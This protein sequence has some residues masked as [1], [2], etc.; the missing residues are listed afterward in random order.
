MRSKSL[1]CAEQVS[2][3]APTWGATHEDIKSTE[4][5]LFQS[6]LPHGERPMAIEVSSIVSCFN[7]RSHMGSDATTDTVKL[8]QKV[9][10]HA[11]T[12]GA[13]LLAEFRRKGWKFQSTLPHGERRYNFDYLNGNSMFQ[14]T[15]P[16]GERLFLSIMSNVMSMFQS[17]LPHGERL[18]ISITLMVTR[19]FNP[20]SHMGSDIVLNHVMSSLILFQSTL[21]HGERPSCSSYSGRMVLFQSTLPHGE[22]HNHS[23]SII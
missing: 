11:P 16:H 10:I 6:T 8:T 12:W 20:R 15:L 23:T 4:R 14:S 2:I 19:C 21:P 13:T 18:I 5:Y 1:V 17:T 9:S 22:R 7:P 3:H